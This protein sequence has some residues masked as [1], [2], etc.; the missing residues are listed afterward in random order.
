M[1]RTLVITALLA[2]LPA[3]PS[4]QNWT[5]AQQDLIDQVKRCNDAWSESIAR[6][7]Y[8]LYEKSCPETAEAVFWYGGEAPARYGGA[9][10]VWSQSSA[11]NRAVTWTDLRPVAVQIDGETALVYY[12]VIWTVQPSEGEPRGNRSRRLTVF[13][14]RDGRWLMAG[15]TIA[16]VN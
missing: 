15:G 7:S 5:P 13:H 3:S 4:A 8:A 14:R 12:T 2:W 10:G 1:K 9:A 6:K 16:P 11:A